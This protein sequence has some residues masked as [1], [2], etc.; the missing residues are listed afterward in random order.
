MKLICL[1]CA[2]GS[3]S[4]F[5]KWCFNG[6]DI[7]PVDLPGRGNNM[8]LDLIKTFNIA[9]EFV[10]EVVLNKINENEK[11][12]LF[13]HSM[14]AYIAFELEHIIKNKPSLLILS[15]INFPCEPI[16]LS[17][18]NDND[19]DLICKLTKFG[20]IPENIKDKHLFANW[21][22]PLIRNDL[23]ILNTYSFANKYSFEEVPI[24]IINSK[25]D[26]IIKRCNLKNWKKYFK[27]V[28]YL[29][30]PGNHF[31]IY[32]ESLFIYNQIMQYY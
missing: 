18:L 22:A 14:G 31:S 27:N 8:H 32:E 3:S 29:Q 7:I 28:K 6:I 1:H 19:E 17:I 11:W 24:I 4:L 23:E 16:S 21:F 2:G 13:G 26:L 12:I 9:L 5:K 30:I 25:D 10:L 20:G 15:G